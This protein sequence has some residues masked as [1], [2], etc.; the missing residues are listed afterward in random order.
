MRFPVPS[1]RA[2]YF[3]N[4]GNCILGGAKTALG[5]KNA[6]R[7]VQTAAGSKDGGWLYN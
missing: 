4:D 3:R 6:S 1:A 7:K 2:G 5:G